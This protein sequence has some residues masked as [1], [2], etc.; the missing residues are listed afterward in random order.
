MKTNT[1]YPRRKQT[2]KTIKDITDICSTC[3]SDNII[4]KLNAVG[5]ML[6]YTDTIKDIDDDTIIAVLMMQMFFLTKP[7]PT[8]PQNNF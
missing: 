6:D 8:L 3:E 7:N 4:S 5:T 2:I 1:A